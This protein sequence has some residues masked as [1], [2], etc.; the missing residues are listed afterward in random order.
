MRKNK[1]YRG[2]NPLDEEY[3]KYVELYT[4]WA[5]SM[6]N[7]DNFDAVYHSLK[8]LIADM[9][10]TQP[11]NSQ[12]LEELQSTK[13]YLDGLAADW[14]SALQRFK[15]SRKATNQLTAMALANK[16]KENKA[17]QNNFRKF[18]EEIRLSA[19]KKEGQT[20]SSS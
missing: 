17:E 6:T 1:V 18:L 19:V 4:I 11:I 3:K 10:R 15:N 9:E 7:K 12:K 13:E 2:G 16:L 8:T 14:P 20:K 5:K